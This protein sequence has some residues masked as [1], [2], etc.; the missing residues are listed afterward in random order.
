MDLTLPLERL[1]RTDLLRRLDENELAYMFRHALIQDTAYRS[2]LRHERKRLHRLIGEALERAFPDAPDEYAARLAQHYAAADDRAKTY[3]YALR[4]GDTA[5][6]VYANAEA[7]TYYTLAL[8][9]VKQVGAE[10]AAYC[11]LYTKLGRALE[12]SSQYDAALA[13]YRELEDLGAARR[14]PPLVLTSLM[15]RATLHATPTPLFDAA[16][17]KELL[18]RALAL[19]QTLNDGAAQAKIYWNLLLLYGFGGDAHSAIE[20]GEKGIALARALGLTE[21]LAYLLNDIA[22]YGYF[23]AGDAARALPTNLEARALWQELG[24]LPMLTDNLNNSSIARHLRGEYDIAELE[25]DRAREVSLAINNFWGEQLERIEHAQ[26]Y[27][28]RGEMAKALAAVRPAFQAT[29]AKQLG[30]ALIGGTGLAMLLAEVGAVDEG[31]AVIRQATTRVDIPLY[32]VPGRGALAYLT[33]RQQGLG[34]AEAYAREL[35]ET[36]LEASLLFA[37]PRI[38]FA[39]EVGLAQGRFAETAAEMENWGDRLRELEL[40]SCLGDAR[41]YQARAL[42]ALGAVQAA[43]EALAHGRAVAEAI[44]C[45]RVL[46]KLY[47]ALGEVAR[48]TGDLPAVQ[49]FQARARAIVQRIAERTSEPYRASFLAR[50]ALEN[51]NPNVYQS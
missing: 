19:A 36:P 1:E 11:A 22:T 51:L 15:L 5:A 40:R 3:T 28:E 30:L 33:F 17:G 35:Q 47:A 12:V 37:L 21:Q 18:D 7:I 10:P 26:I 46:W 49:E 31:Y 44:G 8:D 16:Q 6:R 32:R 24:N 2:L 13:R 48:R 41:L 27:F 25:L 43:Q 34:A 39:G 9:A 45:E 4:A 29:F 38:L 50:A 20:Y 14:E 42:L 23:A